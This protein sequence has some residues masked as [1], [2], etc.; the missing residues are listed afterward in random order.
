M[1]NLKSA[2]W[3]CLAVALLA[4]LATE[5]ALAHH[6]MGGKTPATLM[7][8]LLSGIAHPIIGID[9]LAFVIAV[10]LAGALAGAPLLVPAAFIVGT[11][12]GAGLHLASVALPATE[13]VIS[14]S[15]LLIGVV[16]MLRKALAL[17]MLAGLVALAGLFHGFAY[18]EA[19]FG[20]ETTPL[21]GYLVGFAATQFAIAAGAALLT[22]R[23]AGSATDIANAPRLAGAMVAGV[24]VA[25]LAEKLTAIVFPGVS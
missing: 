11:L 17:P 20:A 23:L 14:A 16:V 2:I 7:Q 24:G 3:R 21:A 4:V 6:A 1:T 15:V 22:D 19:I 9:H 25:L 10:G 13:L 8:G 12:A 5:P 18:A